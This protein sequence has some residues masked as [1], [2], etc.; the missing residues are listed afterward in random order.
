MRVTGETRRSEGSGF[1][2]F[3]GGRLRRESDGVVVPM[4][5]GNAGGGKGPDF[6]SAFKDGD[7]QVIGDEP[8][9]TA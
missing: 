3:C 2:A 5:P 4:K 1:D 7:D 8:R 6:W 9:N